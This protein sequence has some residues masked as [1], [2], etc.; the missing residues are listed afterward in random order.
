M[1]ETGDLA[2][3]DRLLALIADRL[4]KEEDSRLVLKGPP[5]SSAGGGLK[6]EGLDLIGS[7]STA[8]LGPRSRPTSGRRVAEGLD[9]I[10]GGLTAHLGPQG[11]EAR[12]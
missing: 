8:H 7:R 3:R 5:S 6:A 10:G 4:G 2:A 1:T 12:C 11:R 9:L